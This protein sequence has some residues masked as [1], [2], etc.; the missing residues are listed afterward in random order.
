MT[1]RA[2]VGTNPTDESIVSGLS[3]IR[4]ESIAENGSRSNV[5]AKHRSSDNKHIE[6]N[7]YYSYLSASMGSMVIA[8]RAGM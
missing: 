6:L 2:F 4:E 1:P 7:A 3:V 8:R 5:S